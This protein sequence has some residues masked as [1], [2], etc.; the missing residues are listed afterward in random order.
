MRKRLCCAIVMLSI[1]SGCSAVEFRDGTL[2]PLAGTI[3]ENVRPLVEMG[4]TAAVIDGVVSD[5]DA[6]ATRALVDRLAAALKAG[7]LRAALAVDWDDIER[8]A[9]LG[10]ERLLKEEKISEGVATVLLQRIV[11][12]RDLLF[13]LGAPM[14]TI[15]CEARAI[16]DASTTVGG[17]PALV[18]MTTPPM[19]ELWIHNRPRAALGLPLLTEVPNDAR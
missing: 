16:R 4:L 5:E 2:L 18:G 14:T 13:S 17:A 15:R 11:N 19:T 7:D 10:V 8:W 3:L 1:L 12:L 9:T 6:I